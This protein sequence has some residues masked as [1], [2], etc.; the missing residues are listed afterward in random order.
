MLT[1]C[2]DW[3]RVFWAC[4]KMQT[5]QATTGRIGFYVG[6]VGRTKNCIHICRSLGSFQINCVLIIHLHMHLTFNQPTLNCS[7]HDTALQRSNAFIF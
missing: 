6:G 5:N 3:D 1:K 2:K 4:S 7:M